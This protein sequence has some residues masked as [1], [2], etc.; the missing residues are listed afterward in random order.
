M[1]IELISGGAEVLI[2]NLEETGFSRAEIG[3]LY[4]Y[5]WGIET[6]FNHLKN[7]V[8]A[9]TF[10]G[11]KENSIKQEFYAI[12]IKYNLFMLFVEEA[13]MVNRYSKKNFK[14]RI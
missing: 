8:Y 5:R 2:T 1:R 11:I 14:A 13:E 6:G 7:A 9:E 12:L 10:V 4:W 3:K